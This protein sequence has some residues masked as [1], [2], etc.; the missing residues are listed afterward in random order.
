MKYEIRKLD[1]KRGI[2]QIST[3]D[4]RWY[5]KPKDKE[6]TDYV[7]YPSVTWIAEHYPKGIGFYKWLANKGWD[8]A[9]AIKEAA[10]DKG[11]KVHQ[12]CV[13]IDAGKE[14]KFYTKYKNPSTGLDEE[15]TVSEWE[16]LMA[17][18][19]WLDETKPKLVHSEMPVFNE[20]EYYAGTLD[21]IYEIEGELW[22]IDLKTSQNIYPSHEIQLAA[23]AHCDLPYT[24][25]F[26]LAVLQLGYF[27]NKNKY[28]FTP[29]VDKYDL[30]LHAKA[31]WHNENPDAKPKQKDYPISLI[32]ECRKEEE[33][34]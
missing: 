22:I 12:A 17:F 33:K 13:D 11:S 32:A 27:R 29:V 31:I 8:E 14:V 7:Y 15:L 34:K 28:K 25:P 4:E 1:Q 18:R 24:K 5:A 21:R 20:K 6:V 26:K 3:I 23:Y 2:I 19:N 16:C 9:Q 10:G 30:F